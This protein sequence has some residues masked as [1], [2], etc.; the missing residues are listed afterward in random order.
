MGDNLRRYRAIKTALKQ[1]YPGMVK[2]TQARHMNTLAALISGIVSSRRVSLPEIASN[3]PDGNKRESRVKRFARWIQNERIDAEVYFLPF[4]HELL[5]SL[6]E[7][8]LVL[9]IDG[10]ETSDL[11]CPEQRSIWSRTWS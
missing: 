1:V 4:A 6:A 2:G 11:C 7:R 8:T 10:S 9:A 5:V 3:V